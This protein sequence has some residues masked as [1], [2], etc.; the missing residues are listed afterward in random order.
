MAQKVAGKV[1]QILPADEVSN[2]SVGTHAEMMAKNGFSVAVL[3][4]K[5]GSENVRDK[6]RR[7]IPTTKPSYTT[8]LLFRDVDVSEGEYVELEAEPL[9]GTHWYVAPEN[10]LTQ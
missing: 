8:D 2:Y 5:R 9:E 1:T 4:D 3:V 6:I 10:P 7:Y